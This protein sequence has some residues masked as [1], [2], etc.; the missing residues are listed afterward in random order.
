MTNEQFIDYVLNVGRDAL[1]KIEHASTLLKLITLNGANVRDSE[2]ADVAKAYDD[3]GICR[4]SLIST[5]E[6]L[7]D[8]IWSLKTLN[9]RASTST[10][11]YFLFSTGQPDSIREVDEATAALALGEQFTAAQ[12][13]ST[14][15]EVLHEDDKD[16]CT[17]ETAL[18]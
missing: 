2:V 17:T 7:S 4:N 14:D 6:L 16:E 3:V 5:H 1:E 12:D 9:D 8:T 13:T 10:T 18:F 15:D 11:R